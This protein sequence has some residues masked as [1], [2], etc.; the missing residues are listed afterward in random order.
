M[1]ST[2]SS[3]AAVTWGSR[4]LALFATLAM[5]VALPA[6]AATLDRIKEAG[7]IRFGYLPDARPFTYQGE[8]GA[9]EGYT[10]ALCERIATHVKAQ[11]TL[12]Q[13]AVEWV[14]VKFENR[15]QEVQQGN[16]DVLCAPTAVTPSRQETVSFSIP[17]FPGGVRAMMR[18][19]A[20]SALRQALAE[21][22]D[23]TKSAKPSSKATKALLKT[24][25]G[26][27][28]GTT[29]ETWLNERRQS[30]QVDAKV[31]TV[32]DYKAG[33]QA[34]RDRKIDV[35]FGDRALIL[36]TLHET[37]APDLFIF[38]R[39]FT[40]EPFSL[41]LARNDNDFRQLVDRALRELFTSRE[42]RELYQKC[43]GEPDE[44]AR[45]FAKGVAA[46]K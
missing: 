35:F 34:L 12:P 24:T 15:L 23:S 2:L 41:A 16:I 40:Q 27:V 5:A 19:D 1:H 37:G 33:V 4:V 7:R 46:E 38:D 6:S 39:L 20:T 11:L 17:T 31:V 29:T 45:A 44:I 3:P 42:I 13:L 18:L 26:V 32:P 36:G 21:Q 25:L 22:P 43:C 28:S 14:P 10:A 30:L 8:G 9:V